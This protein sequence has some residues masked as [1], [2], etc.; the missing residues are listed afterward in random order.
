MRVD[1]PEDGFRLTAL[2]PRPSAGGR[3]AADDLERL[4]RV[5]ETI[6]STTD[7]FAYIFDPQGRF[8][9]A[10]APLLKVWAKTLDQVVGKTCHELD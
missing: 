1:A 9:Y 4:I 6:L 2:L 7:D 8:L 10:N 3:H 5:Y